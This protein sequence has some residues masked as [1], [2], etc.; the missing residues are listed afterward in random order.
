[1]SLLVKCQI[2]V[3]FTSVLKFPRSALKEYWKLPST[4]FRNLIDTVS[5]VR[6][7]SSMHALMTFMPFVRR[8]VTFLDRYNV[9]RFTDR[10]IALPWQICNLTLRNLL[11]CP[12]RNVNLYWQ[13]CCLTYVYNAFVGRHEP[14]LT[15]M[16]PR[17]THRSIA[18]P[19][20]I[21]NLTL[22]NLLPCLGRYVSV[23]LH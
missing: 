12:G 10:S 8:H 20:Q 16:L 1:M 17:F 5:T 15:D 2:L 18:F 14:F 6:L 7:Y 9:P 21:W 22:R 19:W 3:L 11:P 23:T 4:F 13:I